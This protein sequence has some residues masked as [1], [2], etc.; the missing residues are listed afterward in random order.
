MLNVADMSVFYDEFQAVK[1]VS[2]T[3]DKHGITALI[4]PSGCGKSTFLKSLNRMNDLVPGASVTGLIEYDGQDINDSSVDVTN[5]RQEIGLV[6]QQPNP[7]PFSIY[8]N[9]AYGLK[10]NG[11]KDQAILDEA[12]ESSLRKAAI[13]EE[14]KDKLQSRADSLSGGQQQ[15]VCIARVLAMKPKII[16]MDE[17]TSALDP[18]ST[19]EIEDMLDTIKKEHTII[20][21]THNLQQASRISDRT[22]FFSKGELIEF[23][24][25]KD[26]FLNPEKKATED[27]ISG[28]L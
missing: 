6:F 22:A 8:E 4:G 13:W 14:V 3:F 1:N 2:M 9:V 18:I 28:K 27:Y 5:L 17:P 7:F 19:T 26:I 15:R 20:M 23:G 24:K 11:I 21:V 10:V 16:L 25:T 12:V